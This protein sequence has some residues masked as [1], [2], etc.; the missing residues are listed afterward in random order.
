MAKVRYNGLLCAK[1]P[2][3]SGER[4][5]SSRGCVLCTKERTDR[6]TAK[7]PIKRRR[8]GWKR[9]GIDVAAAEAALQA[10]DGYCDLCRTGTPGTNGWHVDHDHATGKVR[11]VLCY[12]C[13]TSLG[14]TEATGVSKIAAYVR[15]VL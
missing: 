6:W 12:R 7:N 10:H 4:Y 13:N 5:V 1:H 14:W 15:G 3:L 11:G 2:A 9:R 8:R